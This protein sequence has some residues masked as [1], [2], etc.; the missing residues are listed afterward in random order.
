MADGSSMINPEIGGRISPQGFLHA[1]RCVPLWFGCFSGVSRSR[2]PDASSPF[3]Q[4]MNYISS[5]RM[6]HYGF[7]MLTL[8]GYLCLGCDPGMAFPTLAIFLV[9]HCQSPFWPLQD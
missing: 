5:M 8:P 3:G 6:R 2:S 4:L 7:S 9:S 1:F